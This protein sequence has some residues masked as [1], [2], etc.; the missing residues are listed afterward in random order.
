MGF[1]KQKIQNRR[2]AK[3]IPKRIQKSNPTEWER[4]WERS[5]SLA[6]LE[7]RV[8]QNKSHNI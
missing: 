4:D 7:D 2:E 8:N 1:K 3:G 5:L 6:I